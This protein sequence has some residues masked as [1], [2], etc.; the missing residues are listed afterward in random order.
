MNPTHSSYTCDSNWEVLGIASYS[1]PQESKKRAERT[2]PGV[3]HCWVDAGVSEEE[4]LAYQE[5]VSRALQCGFCGK[6][7]N[8]G[9]HVIEKNGRRICSDCVE[10]VYKAL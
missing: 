10:E 3:S 1:S 8:Q 6:E 5:E 9:R 7:P 2:Y 4:A